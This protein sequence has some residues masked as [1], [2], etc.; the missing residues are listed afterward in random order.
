MTRLLALAGSLLVLGTVAARAADLPPAAPVYTPPPPEVALIMDWRG[1]YIGLNGGWGSGSPSYTNVTNTTAF[2]D[3]FPGQTFS[4]TMNGLVG[5]GHIG[6]N[7]QASNWVFGLE[8]MADG[9]SISGT[10]TPVANAF[11]TN[12]NSMFLFTGRIGGAFGSFLPYVKGGYALAGV[13]A[14]VTDFVGDGGAFTQYVGG[15]TVGAG[16][17]VQFWSRVSVGIEYNYVMLDSARYE[18]AG[19][20]GTYQFDMQAKNVS[21]VLGRFNF[22]FGP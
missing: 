6:W 13:R 12:I 4:H 8:A 17:E 18:L 10:T 22:R 2:G 11:T 16:L 9:T 5:G 15:P 14:R 19:A 21:L 1:L 20:A 7:W 3:I